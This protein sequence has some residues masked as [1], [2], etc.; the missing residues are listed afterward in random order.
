[1]ADINDHLTTV[2]DTR[3]QEISV[4]KKKIAE[5]TATNEG[6]KE[7][8]MNEVNQMRERVRKQTGALNEKITVRNL[9]VN[10]I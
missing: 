9:F 2:L 8:H 3:D 10:Y 6:N 1:M 5:L 4:M 7:E